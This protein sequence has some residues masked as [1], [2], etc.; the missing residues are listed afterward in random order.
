MGK[1]LEITVLVADKNPDD[2]ELQAKAMP[3]FLAKGRI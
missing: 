3:V 2:K 1:A